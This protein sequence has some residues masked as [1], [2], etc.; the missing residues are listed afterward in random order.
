MKQPLW[1]IARL[2][3]DGQGT[4][5][6]TRTQRQVRGRTTARVVVVRTKWAFRSAQIALGPA[7]RDQ[8]L[9]QRSPKSASSGRDRRQSTNPR[10]TAESEKNRAGSP[11]RLEHHIVHLDRGSERDLIHLGSKLRAQFRYKRDLIHLGSKL[12]VKF[13][14]ERDLIH[15]GSKLRVKFRYERDLIHLGSKLRVQSRLKQQALL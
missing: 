4:L 7:P 11:D 1:S 13:R 12:R 14:Y 8:F 3:D 2:A 5:G 9:P 15:L 10:S 6:V